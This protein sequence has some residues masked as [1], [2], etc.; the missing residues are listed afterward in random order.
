MPP[1]ECYPRSF[2][3]VSGVAGLCGGIALFDATTESW[4]AVRHPR[5]TRVVVTV[6][7]LYG[8]VQTE[9]AQT[10]LITYPTS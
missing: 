7:A 9:R 3:T 5:D 2:P 6:T 1:A 10:Q 4:N 8:L